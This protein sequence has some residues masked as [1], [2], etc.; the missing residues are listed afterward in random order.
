MTI[1]LFK[2]R[3][4]GLVMLVWNAEENIEKRRHIIQIQTIDNAKHS[5]CEYYYTA[6][7]TQFIIQNENELVQPESPTQRKEFMAV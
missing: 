6:N 4:K 3:P 7:N 1:I 2:T 5:L